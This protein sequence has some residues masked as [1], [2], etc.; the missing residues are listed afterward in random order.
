MGS[1]DDVDYYL[2]YYILFECNDCV[3]TGLSV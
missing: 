2:G 3:V 1:W